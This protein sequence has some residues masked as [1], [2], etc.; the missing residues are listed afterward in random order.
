MN[1]STTPR[2][3]RSRD[4]KQT[5]IAVIGTGLAGLTTAHLLSRSPR[6]SHLSIHLFE[7]GPKIGF[8]AHS[9]EV[10]GR[11][12]D[13]PMR[14]V[15]SGYYPRL[16]G[17]YRSLGV[18]LRRVRFTYSFSDASGVRLVYDGG[19]GRSGVR[20]SSI[21]ET[22]I[23]SLTFIYFAILA[24]L[25]THLL[26]RSKILSTT[27][28]DTFLHMHHIPTS[29]SQNYLI[30]LFS[31]VCTC[32]H[33]TTLRLPAAEVLRYAAASLWGRHYVVE[34]G[35][36][37]VRE[38]LMEGVEEE[39]VHLGRGVERVR[40]VEGR[41]RLKL[42]GG[43]NEEEEFEHVVF[44][45]GTAQAQQ[46]LSSAK[47]GEHE[48]EDLARLLDAFESEKVEVVTHRD[49]TILPTPHTHLRT[50]NLST[51]PCTNQTSTTHI[52]SPTILQTT[53]PSPT[54][55]IPSPL[56]LGRAQFYRGIQTLV[57][58]ETIKELE[59][60]QGRDGVWFVGSWTRGGLVLLEGCVE[61][62]EGV[63]RGILGREGGR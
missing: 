14:A 53:N 25:Y 31:A 17:L 45:V 60:V 33:S 5:R 29:F 23:T 22:L 36:R 8:D 27:T 20:A 35:V 18:R 55:T 37:V 61:G 10:D 16:M 9:L 39:N 38:R 40:R 52:I 13:V 44:A 47:E 41:M 26:P 57:S 63:V 19:S 58:L 49:T 42:E 48:H 50:L 62:A 11:V 56:L 24:I 7:A 4:H 30:P 34:G 54:H 21:W 2:P 1:E 28:L 51:H 43:E 12:V 15:T 46:I 59:R 32:S 3:S 6:S